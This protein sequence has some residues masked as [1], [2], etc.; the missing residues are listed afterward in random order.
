MS[1]SRKGEKNYFYGKHFVGKKNPFYGKHHSEESKRKMSEARRKRVTL[2]TTRKKMSE[3]RKGDKNGNWKGGR[4]RSSGYIYIYLPTHPCASKLGYVMEHRLI[5]ETHIGR[6]LLPTEIVHHINGI[7]D[8][9]RLENLQLFSN[10]GEHTA[11]HNK[12][13]T[14]RTK[15]KQ[16]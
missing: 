1:P 10:R 2:E 13:K 6:T 14:K 12:Q 8:D 5:M 3:T 4:L 11:M 7:V 15:E 9:N 16:C